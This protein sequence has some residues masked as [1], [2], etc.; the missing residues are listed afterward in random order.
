MIAPR[1]ICLHFARKDTA[2]RTFKKP[3]NHFTPLIKFT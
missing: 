2:Y 1:K 3:F